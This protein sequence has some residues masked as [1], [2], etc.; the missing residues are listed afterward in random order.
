MLNRITRRALQV[1]IVL[2]AI[3][4]VTFVMVVSVPGN[5]FQREGSRALPPMLEQA[6]RQRYGMENNWTFYWRYLGRV[7]QGDLGESLQYDNWSCSEI[8]AAGLPVSAAIGLAAIL[9]A[10]VFGTLLGAIAALHRG[11]LVD[12]VATSIAV[13]GVSTPA[14]VIAAVLLI[15]FSVTVPVLS[16]GT[17]DSPL[18]LLRPAVAL[19]LA[20]LAYILRLTRQSMAEVLVSDFIRTA[21]AKGLSQAAV[22][23]RHALRNGLLPTLSYLGPAAAAAMTGSFI[24]ERVFNVPGL[25]THFVN[26]VLN[27]D[28]M[29]I[30]ATVLVYSTMLVVFNLLVDLAYGL[31]DPRIQSKGAA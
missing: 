17:W 29:L 10:L 12:L 9:I 27:R 20:P 21:R 30:L 11:R 7:L 3:Y 31:I 6:L 28:Q 13:L 14:F 22:I 16:A 1:P 4:T 2:L 25:G 18:D 15:G 5:P 8:I 26:S 23:W 24:V 19:A